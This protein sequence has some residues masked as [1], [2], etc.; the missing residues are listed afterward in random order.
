VAGELQGAVADPRYAA[1]LAVAE[2]V[3][4]CAVVMDLLSGFSGTHAG[5]ADA[6]YVLG[7]AAHAIGDTVRSLDFSSRA[8]RTLRETGRIGL[9]SQVLSMQVMDLLELGDWDRAA[10]AAEEGVRLAAETGQPIWRAG[11]LVCD[12]LNHAFRGQTE[13]AFRYAAEAEL[14][15]SQR[16]L[17]DLLCCV[18]LA[19]GAT[20][21]STGQHTAAYRE[22]RRMFEPGD[23][24]FHQRERYDGVMFLADAAVRAGQ[25]DDARQ[26]VG[27]LELLAAATP[28]PQ[29]HIHLAYA[30]AVLADDSEAGPFYADLMA[31][32][33]SR[34]PWA[35]A[36]VALAY[37]RWL[38]HQGRYR[39][40]EEALRP[41]P[42]TFERIGATDWARLARSEMLLAGAGEPEPGEPEP[43]DHF[44]AGGG[45]IC[46]PTS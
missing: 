26:V 36:R 43:R 23:P 45:G 24:C 1:V 30:R 37:G 35:G 40:S 5:D 18:A 12:A 27:G 29:L 42:D 22:F 2:P 31:R 8:E 46:H 33:L 28:A 17:N 11:T 6:L 20:L 38:L 9:L 13:Q 32:D 21:A 7:M 25:R 19:R 15:L 41:L 34:W 44:P 14:V 4:Q 39:A 16:R 3:R 10:A